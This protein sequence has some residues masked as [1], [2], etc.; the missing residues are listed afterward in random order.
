[1]TSRLLVAVTMTAREV[2]RNRTAC[3]LALV[4]PLL[5]YALA[6]LMTS[7]RIVVFQ[8]ASLSLEP[9]IEVSGRSNALV[10]MAL[11]AIGPH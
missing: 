5:F 8:L 1:M 7:E 6:V 3:V 11:I 10:F 2:A 4:L 9:D